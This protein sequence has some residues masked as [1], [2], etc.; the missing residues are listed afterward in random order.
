MTKKDKIGLCND[1][2]KQ[3]IRTDDTW[4]RCPDSD[5]GYQD[6]QPHPDRVEKA[7][8]TGWAVVKGR[9]PCS[10]CDSAAK[11]H[12]CAGCSRCS[13]CCPDWEGHGRRA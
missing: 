8:S 1:C 10:K 3:M 2:D 7:F 6:V 11:E 12:Y 9:E 5:C 4:V 13:D